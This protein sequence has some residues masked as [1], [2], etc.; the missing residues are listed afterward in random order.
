MELFLDDGSEVKGNLY[1]TWVAEKL[2]G[3]DV[4]WD[5]RSSRN[6]SLLAFFLTSD[7][8][9]WYPLE[10]GNEKMPNSWHDEIL[11]SRISWFQLLNMHFNQSISSP[12][13]R[14]PDRGLHWTRWQLGGNLSKAHRQL[15]LCIFTSNMENPNEFTATHNH[16]PHSGYVSLENH[17]FRSPNELRILSHGFKFQWVFSTRKKCHTLGRIP[18][19]WTLSSVE[20][21]I[22]SGNMA[23]M[24]HL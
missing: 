7:T 11:E 2:T 20:V 4:L 18:P 14:F 19:V 16:H 9:Q 10:K 23:K 15:I 22:P 1:S 6:L 21:H 17:M 13:H 8:C 12:S 5:H 3:Q 24:D